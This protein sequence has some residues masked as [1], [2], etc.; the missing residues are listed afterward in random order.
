MIHQP[1]GGMQ[2]QATDMQ[3]AAEHIIKLKQ[4]LN[5]LLSENTNQSYEK[6]SNDTERDNYMFANEALEY[7]LIDKIITKL[8]K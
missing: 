8:E 6:I 5:K 1:L 3:I 7:G 2:G 4:R